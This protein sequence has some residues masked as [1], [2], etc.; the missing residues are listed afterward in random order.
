M[1][2]GR[3]RDLKCCARILLSRRLSSLSLTLLGSS[4]AP[5]AHLP[6]SFYGVV[7]ASKGS[8]QLEGIYKEARQSVDKALKEFDEIIG[9]LQ[10][11][12]APGV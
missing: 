2:T 12:K 8:T 11:A 9:L 6:P 1:T 10:E 5:L 3:A 7:F 4:L